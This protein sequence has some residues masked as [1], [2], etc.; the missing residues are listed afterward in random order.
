VLGPEGR[1]Y[2]RAYRLSITPT[3]CQLNDPLGDALARVDRLI[4]HVKIG[5]C[6]E[7]RPVQDVQHLTVERLVGNERTDAPR[8][9]GSEP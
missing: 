9:F 5:A 4:A 7:K 8:Q 6:P 1:G 3:V 2:C